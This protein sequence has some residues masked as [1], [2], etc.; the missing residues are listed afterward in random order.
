MHWA[1]YIIFNSVLNKD[2]KSKYVSVFLMCLKGNTN[3]QALR[4]TDCEGTGENALFTI[5][6][7]NL[8]QNACAIF[9]TDL[10]SKAIRKD[11]HIEIFMQWKYKS[12]PGRTS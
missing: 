10:K 6:H 9:V 4:H 2:E 11:D 5:L 7:N 1:T 3:V 8:T 12:I